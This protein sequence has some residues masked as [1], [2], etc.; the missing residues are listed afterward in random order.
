MECVHCGVMVRKGVNR[1]WNCERDPRP[2]S[3]NGMLEGTIGAAAIVGGAAIAW[4]VIRAIWRPTLILFLMLAL[5]R[6]FGWEDVRW[7]NGLTGAASFIAP[8]FL[9]SRGV[10]GFVGIKRWQI[11][12]YGVIGLCSFLSVFLGSEVEAASQKVPMAPASTENTTARDAITLGVADAFPVRSTTSQSAAAS[13]P[14]TI[15]GAAAVQPTSGTGLDSAEVASQFAPVAQATCVAR[16]VE[17]WRRSAGTDAVAKA[18]QLE[19]WE[20]WCKAGKV[21]D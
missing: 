11:W 5:W 15:G 21:P 20:D 7:L 18:D 10:P 17:L 3:E 4:V 19:E 9:N 16:W 1:C 2:A 12:L 6:A 13:A 14:T 8:I